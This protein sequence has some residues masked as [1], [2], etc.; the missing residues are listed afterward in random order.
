MSTD[1]LTTGTQ[2]RV[3]KKNG[4]EVLLLTS[5]EL[6]ALNALRGQQE[7]VK[8]SR[9]YPNL[10]SQMSYSLKDMS[11]VKNSIFEELKNLDFECGTSVIDFL[12][13][14]I[15]LECDQYLTPDDGDDDETIDLSRKGARD[16]S[17]NIYA[18]IT[19]IKHLQKIFD[20]LERMQT[21]SNRIEWAKKRV[22][23]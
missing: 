22:L 5:E 16:L 17:S 6:S 3:N 18:K 13:D 15:Y 11:E 19:A 23:I 9:I 14:S 21:V 4:Q 20:Y 1:T 10:Y 7:V 2:E 12:L 8:V